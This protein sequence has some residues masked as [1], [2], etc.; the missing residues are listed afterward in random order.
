V[1]SVFLVARRDGDELVLLELPGHDVI[2]GLA[3]R[4]DLAREAPERTRIP[5]PD[6]E[7]LCPTAYPDKCSSM[8]CCRRYPTR[9]VIRKK[10][11]MCLRTCPPT[12]VLT[13][14]SGN[15][16]TMRSKSAC[17]SSRFSADSG[18]VEYSWRFCWSGAVER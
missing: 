16:F 13:K 10:S 17:A 11:G 6:A 9:S 12:L 2:R 4:I 5:I 7:L 18:R 14:R 8:R 3:D 15:N 1:W